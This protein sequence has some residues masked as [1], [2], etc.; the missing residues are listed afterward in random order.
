MVPTIIRVICATPT[1]DSSLVSKQDNKKSF[2][3]L[4]PCY[5][6]KVEHGLTEITDKKN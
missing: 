1:L 2:F 5:A 6:G 4:T 3:D